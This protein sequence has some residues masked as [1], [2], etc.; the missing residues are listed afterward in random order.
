M[1]IE[2]DLSKLDG[3]LSWASFLAGYIKASHDTASMSYVYAGDLQTAL[4]ELR[5]SFKEQIA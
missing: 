4:D 5:A 3:V 1:K 2:V